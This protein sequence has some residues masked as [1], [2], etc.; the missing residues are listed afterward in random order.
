[1]QAIG[2][3]SQCVAMLATFELIFLF[4]NLLFAHQELQGI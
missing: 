3:K 4:L 1:M 2:S